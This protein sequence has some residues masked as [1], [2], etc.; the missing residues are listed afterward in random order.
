MILVLYQFKQ[1]K[2]EMWSRAAE[3]G[4][5]QAY[6]GG[7]ANIQLQTGAEQC[8][9]WMREALQ[10]RSRGCRCGQDAKFNHSTF[11]TIYYTVLS[12]CVLFYCLLVQ[13]ISHQAFCFIIFILA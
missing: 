9:C 5:F 1:T 13:S 4:G 6:R 12:L 8:E 10:V 3:S 11:T 2:N 7:G